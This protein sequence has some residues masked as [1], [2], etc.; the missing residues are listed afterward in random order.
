MLSL[1]IVLTILSVFGGWQGRPKPPSKPE[2]SPHLTL[3]GFTL[4]RSTLADVQAKLGSSKITRTDAGQ[5]SES[6]VCYL[7]PGKNESEVFFQSGF[8]GG[9]VQLDG[10]K[11]TSRASDR[12]SQC[13]AADGPEFEIQTLGGLRLGLSR[14]ETTQLLGSPTSSSRDGLRYVWKSR[15]PM[16]R[17]ELEK[18]NQTFH[19][20]LKSGYWDIW[21]EIKL[22]FA[23]SKVVEFEISHTVSD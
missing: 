4:G 20:S 5:D 22:R 7:I 6:E 3:L 19:T 9:W 13:L 23:G 11:V 1:H 17:D 18:A 14:E 10:F 21:D 16:R 15:K 8:S 2:V 12:D